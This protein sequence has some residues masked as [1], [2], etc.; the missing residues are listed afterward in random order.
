MAIDTG[1]VFLGKNGPYRHSSGS[2]TDVELWVSHECWICGFSNVM[3]PR[4]A[5]AHLGG[6]GWRVVGSYF[7]VYVESL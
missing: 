1:A 7:A 3:K 4:E 5:T 6:P 2:S